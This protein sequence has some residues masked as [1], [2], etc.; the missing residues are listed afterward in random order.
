MKWLFRAFLLLMLVA[1]AGVGV[2]Y[3]YFRI[4]TTPL[5]QPSKEP[6]VV[7]IR[8]GMLGSDIAA[9]LK[10]QRL[11]EDEFAFRLLLRYHPKGRQ[12]GVG[13]FGLHSGPAPLK[14]YEELLAARPLTRRATFPEGLLIAEMAR[15]GQEEK[16]FSSADKFVQLARQRGQSY[17]KLFPANLEGYLLPD[18]YEFPYKCDEQ[19][20]L[21]RFVSEFQAQ[22]LPLWEK[23]R[24]KCPL[25]SLHEVLVLAS[26]VEREAQ[27]DRERGV[28]AGVYVNR[29][30]KDMKLECDATVQFALGKT[31]PLLTFADLE[32][33]SPYNTYR[34]KG[35]PPGPI[36]NPGIR[37]IRAALQPTPSEYLYYVRDDIKNDGSHR[38]GKTYAEHLANC[39]RYQR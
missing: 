33:E 16:L 24:A 5:G 32:V 9:E 7:E 29:L 17:G 34:V 18:T 20:V 14:L 28:I 13:V 23:H 6:V 10:K 38:F 4:L 21:D 12:L 1:L 15:I 39:S 35:L 37:S 31:K 2:A 27:V 22:V 26:L 36:A 25:K 30:R 11:I 8:E 19:V 3:H